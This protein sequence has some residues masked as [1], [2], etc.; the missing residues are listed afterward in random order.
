LPLFF[1]H[2]A[3]SYGLGLIPIK[4]NASFTLLNISKKQLIERLEW[5]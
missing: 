2:A 1:T 5:L 3:L 4:L